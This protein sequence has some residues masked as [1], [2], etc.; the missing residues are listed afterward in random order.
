MEEFSIA[1]KRLNR[2]RSN[3]SLL[4]TT[5]A[6]SIKTEIEVTDGHKVAS[7]RTMSVYGNRDIK[8]EIQDRPFTAIMQTDTLKFSRNNE[9]REI[10]Q[11]KKRFNRHEVKK[12][13]K[14]KH[15]TSKNR[16]SPNKSGD[17][18]TR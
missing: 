4:G 17:S 1:Q 12:A 6:K 3:Y 9:L 15:S 13:N 11:I 2:A 16:V 5:K 18:K 14:D 7:I 8:H 10:D